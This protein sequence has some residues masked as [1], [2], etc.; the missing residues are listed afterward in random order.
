LKVR[1]LDAIPSAPSPCKLILM[2]W[3]VVLFWGMLALAIWL[4]PKPRPKSS[5]APQVPG[6]GLCRLNATGLFVSWSYECERMTGWSQTEMLGRHFADL[7]PKKGAQRNQNHPSLLEAFSKGSF[8][9]EYWA[10]RANGA[11]YFRGVLISPHLDP[12]TS[13]LLGFDVLIQD[14]TERKVAEDLREESERRFAESEKTLRS[15]FKNLIGTVYRAE[16]DAAWTRYILS[17]NFEEICGYP[18]TDFLFNK[19]RTFASIVHP[20]DIA[21][22]LETIKKAIE[23]H[24]PFEVEYRIFRADGGIRWLQ[25]R[26]SAFRNEQGEALFID[27]FC[28]DVTERKILEQSLDEERAA[29]FASSKLASLGEMAAGIAHEINNPLTVIQG[30]GIQLQ[31]LLESA[32]PDLKKAREWL[33]QIEETTKRIAKIVSSMRSVARD[34][35]LDRLEEVEL[36]HIIEDVM[37]ISRERFRSQEVEFKFDK[38]LESNIIICRPVQMSQVFLNLIQNALDA[39]QELNER[40]IELTFSSHGECD[41]IAFTDSGPGIPTSLAEKIMQPFFTTKANRQGTGLGLSISRKIIESHGGQLTIDQNHPHTRF[42]IRIPKVKT[43]H[44]E[45]DLEA[46]SHSGY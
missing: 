30:R 44:D 1:T 6:F 27:G 36:G 4:V 37:A 5:L 9:E 3:L 28:F 32:N 15:L 8:Y 26:G 29:A 43:I 12:E 40:W 31:K 2:L 16:L 25:D 45:S 38:S 19:I 41:E 14:L 23:N 17:E 13:Q 39:I 22:A 18:S 21:P 24:Q 42:V 46:E 10:I 33:R 20:E 7:T 35:K 11:R 34:G